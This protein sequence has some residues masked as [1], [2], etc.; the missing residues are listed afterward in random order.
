M[1]V[2]SVI[3]WQN[4]TLYQTVSW[5]LWRAVAKGQ[6]NKTEEIRNLQC[7]IKGRWVD[8]REQGSYEVPMQK[9]HYYLLVEWQANVLD[10][11]CSGYCACV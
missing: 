1:C 5:V 2:K 7:W 3:K 8:C 10:T 11:T 9:E 4:E 6:N